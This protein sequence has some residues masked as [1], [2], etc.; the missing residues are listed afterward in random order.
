MSDQFPAEIWTRIFSLACTDDG[1]TGR[2]ISLVSTYIHDVSL[3]IQL[4]SI[5]LAGHRQLHRFADMLERRP[6]H[7]R[8]VRNLCVSHESPQSAE[9]LENAAFA[10]AWNKYN[11]V[12]GDPT[13]LT[14][15]PSYPYI[16]DE[17]KAFHQWIKQQFFEA[18]ARVLQIVAPDVQTLALQSGPY[19]SPALLNDH[20]PSLVE[21]AVDGVTSGL[22]DP[23]SSEITLPRFPSLKYLHIISCC[24][25]LPVFA[26]HAPA[27]THL[28]LSGF[29]FSDFTGSV[30]KLIRS[31][32]VKPADD[33]NMTGTRL[34]HIE[35]II[36]EPVAT[37]DTYRHGV[38]NRFYNE[39]K[40]EDLYAA[41]KLVILR[42]FDNKRTYRWTN[43]RE[44]WMARL[45]GGLGC[46]KEHF[47]LAERY[48][49]SGGM[50]L[51]SPY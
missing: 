31:A 44:D 32:I 36:I 16:V 50:L 49:P 41:N 33:R 9:G 38:L 37:R 22:R 5:A 29:A 30:T 23:Q 15:Q 48:N 13:M 46:W 8:N 51:H 20:F 35:Q 24:S 17:M 14:Q 1:S 18:V 6:P 21:L 28:R 42:Q 47:D 4:Q 27:L 43:A 25:N 45:C 11:V 12:E 2:S 26:D 39:L 3:P 10:Q 34:S 19:F 40:L 7:L